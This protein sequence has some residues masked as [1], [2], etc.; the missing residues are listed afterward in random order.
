V[1]AEF[2]IVVST[3]RELDV[4]T[5]KVEPTAQLGSGRHDELASRVEDEVVSRCELR[6]VVE[7]VE[8]GTLPRTEFKAKRVTD[9]RGQRDRGTPDRGK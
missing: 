4:L 5:V 6:P 8:I 7:V 1:G 2:Q 9:T 3:E